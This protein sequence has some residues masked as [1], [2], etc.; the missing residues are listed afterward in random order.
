MLPD[1]GRYDD[2]YASLIMQ[3]VM[4]ERNLHVHFGKPFVWQQRNP[5]NLIKDLRAEIDG[6]DNILD[7]AEALDGVVLEKGASV[8]DHTAQCYAALQ[9]EKCA[10]RAIPVKA[11]DA[12]FAFMEDIKGVL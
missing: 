6:M 4:R 2:I 7:L 12:A 5:H 8:L 1:V 11:I 3:R 9:E 10:P